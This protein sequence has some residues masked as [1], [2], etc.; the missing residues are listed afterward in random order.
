MREAALDE[1][2][3]DDRVDVALARAEVAAW[4]VQRL[5]AERMAAIVT[6]IR[7]AR[8][9]PHVYVIPRDEPTPRDVAF[10]V[11]AAIADI[12]VRLSLSEG[13]VTAL[14]RR[15]EL[16]LDRAPTVWSVFREGEIS[17]QN[18]ACVADVLESLP[19]DPTT[20]AR[21]AVRALELARLVPTR[22]RERLRAFRD[23]V[24]PEAQRE[25]HE[26][27]R[28]AR[29]AWLDH[30]V[31]GMAWLGAHL[32]SV[33]AETAWQRVDGIA[34]E[35]A[36]CDGEARTLDQLRADAIADILTGR[37]DPATEPRVT[38]GVLVPVLTLLGKDDAPATLDGRIPIDAETARRLATHAPS[39]HRILTHP[40]SS[41]VVDVDRT[42]YR[43]PAD[44]ARLLALRD[45]TCRHPGC[46]RPAR[47]CD[48]DHTIDWATGGTTSV[49]NLAHLSRRH[50]TL[51]HRT[52]WKVEQ[53][54][55]GI[56]RWTSPTGFVQD[57]DPPPF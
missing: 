30:D 18:A 7:E 52:R 38:V 41:A 12:A 13:S 20:D 44:L 35:L 39:F 2:R 50:H 34:R 43:P 4:Q 16:L 17:A 19:V 9:S 49:R 29:R 47:G 28:A 27:A 54:R 24:H 23:R 32:T 40:I 42:S 6:V 14:V 15:G 55:E 5:E 45:V 36:T 3:A 8:R 11:E 25:R 48:I 31:D 57:A 33:D 53:T 51:K 56:I 22:F 37:N 46:G 1:S 21:V 10:A 26:R